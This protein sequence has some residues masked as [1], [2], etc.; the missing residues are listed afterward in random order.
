MSRLSSATV[1]H[2]PVCGSASSEPLQPPHPS[3]SITSGGIILN[4]PLQHLQCLDCGLSWQ[5]TLSDASKAD[6]YQNKY[7]LYHQRGGT[8]SYEDVRYAA[9]AS[10]ILGEIA[11][12]VPSS[13]LDVGCG[14][15]FLLDAM[16]LIHSSADYDGID[17]S[18]ENSALARSRGF[19]VAT[20][21]VPGAVSARAQYDLITVTNVMSHITDTQEF[22][23]SLANMMAPNGRL[24]IY[25]HDGCEPGADLLWADVAFS[26]CREHIVLLG[27]KVGLES[28]EGRH[29]TPPKGQLDKDVLVLRRRQSSLT[30]PLE[31]LSLESRR[32][33][34]EGR[35]QYFSAWR[36][37][38][39]RLAGQN[40]RDA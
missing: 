36:R 23:R 1:S 2:C 15:G 38:A 11:P 21:F 4:T 28:V 34:L 30:A 14:G 17:P 3:R 8:S 27:S 10:W 6:L 24:A 31:E 25:F 16:R 9:M 19:A 20:G 39:D 37:L 12:F 29:L 33:L 13:V 35:R 40:S 18:V 22:L 5:N 26:F 7:R 32:R